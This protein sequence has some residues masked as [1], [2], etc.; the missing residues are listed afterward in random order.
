MM[1]FEKDFVKRK[2]FDF[3]LRSLSEHHGLQEF[4]AV[5][6]MGFVQSRLEL[7]LL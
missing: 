3:F 7:S 6:P 1:G 4:R 5:S 2:D